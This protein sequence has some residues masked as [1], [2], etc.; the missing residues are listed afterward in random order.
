MRLK[1]LVAAG[2]GL[3]VLGTTFTAAQTQV[4]VRIEN[5]APANGTYLTPVWVGFHNGG[6]DIFDLGQPA[7]AALEALAE[8]G[9]TGPLAASFLGSGMG[10][11]EG[12]IGGGPFGPGTVLTMD[13][14]LDGLAATSRYF[15]FA[16]MVVPSNDAFIGNDNPLA[17][18][19]FDAGG[20]FV[21]ADFIVAGSMILDA[22]TEVN[23]EIPANTAFFGQMT[24]NTGTDENGVVHLHPGYLAPGSGGILDDP[25]FAN[26]DFTAP[27]YQ[28]ARITIV[29]EPSGAALL[30]C[31]AAVGLLRRRPA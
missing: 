8:D 13:F 12:T 23:D 27:G 3:A 30:L 1:R 16:S 29:P 14:M 21:G 17:W 22:G 7:S 18:E 9:M 11:V 20:N 24:P 10:T 25:M 15:S 2:I 28:A 6:F 5:L 4:T 19:I 31:I 26:A